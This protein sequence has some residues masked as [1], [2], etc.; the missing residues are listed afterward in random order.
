MP[1]VRFKTF[2]LNSTTG[3]L[4]SIVKFSTNTPMTYTPLYPLWSLCNP[5]YGLLRSPTPG[6]RFISATPAGDPRPPPFINP[7][8]SC[9]SCAFSSVV[10]INVPVRFPFGPTR[11][12]PL[13]ERPAGPK[14]PPGEGATWRDLLVGS[15]G[16]S[17]LA[18]PL[19]GRGRRGRRPAG[20]R[21]EKRPLAPCFHLTLTLS[22]QRRG[23][24][25]RPF[26]RLTYC[27]SLYYVVAFFVC[28]SSV[29]CSG[30]SGFFGLSAGS[31][32]LGGGYVGSVR[33]G[34]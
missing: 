11:L 3:S 26:N 6:L 5:S 34:Y 8:N 25:Q 23:E 21:A 12:S 33:C 14:A 7:P 15:V 31:L 17:I 2:S 19:R 1:A 22:L 10:S 20:S 13:R 4:S 28:I 27:R 16:H 32:S 18:S 30:G 29:C 9:Y 24:K